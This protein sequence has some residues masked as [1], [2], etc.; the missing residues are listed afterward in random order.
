MSTDRMVTI[1]ARVAQEFID[2]WAH[3]EPTHEHP[4][5]L[6]PVADHNRHMLDACKTGLTTLGTA[7][8]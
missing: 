8:P 7:A 6:G 5:R 2:A 1:P 4:G 3:M